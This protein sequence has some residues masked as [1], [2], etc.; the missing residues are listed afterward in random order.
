MIA[1]ISLGAWIAV[2]ICGR[3]LTFYR[4]ATCQAKQ[5]A[6]LLTCDPR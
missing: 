2:I 1:A 4:P 5:E 6:L 3:L